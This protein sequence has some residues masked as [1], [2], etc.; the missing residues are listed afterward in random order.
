MPKIGIEPE[1]F[2]NDQSLTYI[3]LV[4]S[5]MIATWHSSIHAIWQSC[6]SPTNY[7]KYK[8]LFYMYNTNPL[9]I[10]RKRRV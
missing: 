9:L 10:V 4:G 7:K 3:G 8:L 6:V 2:N 1:W 5:R